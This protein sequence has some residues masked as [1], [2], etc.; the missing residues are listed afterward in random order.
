[1]PAFTTTLNLCSSSHLVHCIQSDFCL[2]DKC[3]VWVWK[4]PLF[5]WTP[6]CRFP[7]ST[8]QRG[9]PE[10]TNGQTFTS[11]FESSNL[12][13]AKK[14]NSQ[15]TKQKET[16]KQQQKKKPTQKQNH[17][18]RHKICKHNENVI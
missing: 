16:K 9:R 3:N 8:S 14:K 10:L 13:K 12:K 6:D 15:P 1:M 4:L 2:L 7:Q 17:A 11:W 18:H 5:S